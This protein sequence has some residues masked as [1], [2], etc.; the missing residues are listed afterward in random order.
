MEQRRQFEKRR[1]NFDVITYINAY[2][3]KKKEDIADVVMM[4]S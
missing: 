4:M 1:T 3:T 2:D